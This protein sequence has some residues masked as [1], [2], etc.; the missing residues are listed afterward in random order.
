[1]VEGDALVGVV[2]DEEV[3]VE[4]DPVGEGGEVE[5]GGD[6]EGGFDHTA[7][8]DFEVVVAGDVGH[9]DG[10]EEAAG[11][12]EF[13]VDA[14]AFA[15]E[16]G[17]VGGGPG[18]LVED[19]GEGGAFGEPGVVVQAAGGEGLFDEFDAALLGEPFD[20]FE[21]V[22]A[23]FPA[24]VG[25]DADGGGGGGADGLEAVAVGGGAEFDFD[26]VE[27]GGG[28]GFLVH[29]LR[30]IDAD[31]EAGED[32]VEGGGEVEEAVE[33]E[34]GAFGLPVEEGHFEGGAGSAGEEEWVEGVEVGG[35][36]GGG[37]AGEVGVDGGGGF[38]E[39]AVEGG[40][41]FTGDAVVGDLDEGVAFGGGGAAGDFPG[42]AEAQFVFVEG[43]AR[44]HGEVVARRGGMERV[45]AGLGGRRGRRRPQGEEGAG[46][47]LRVA[48][49]L[50]LLR[51]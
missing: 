26:G 2:G 31:G 17:D 24:A 22:F 14:V 32:G 42:V 41:A 11:F 36:E 50:S 30:S 28:E 19:D 27:V 48:N 33:G 10:F 51:G 37:G 20:H 3:A 7:E 45:E 9:G 21:G 6:G 35:G 38:A 39:V 13:D 4:I 25:V 8:H 16:G 29:S 40:L 1:M 44:G 43:D 23:G 34:V 46:A 5:G 15:G 12:H 47:L 18:V 49:P